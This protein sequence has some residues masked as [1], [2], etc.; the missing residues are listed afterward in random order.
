MSQADLVALALG[1]LPALPCQVTGL[2]GDGGKSDLRVLG[3]SPTGHLQAE[4]PVIDA[5]EG[6]E[7]MIKVERGRGGFLITCRVETAYFM[8]GLDGLVDLEVISVTRRKPHRA[9]Q[10][11]IVDET[12]QIDVLLAGRVAPGATVVAR[13]LDI[14][15]GGAAFLT[16]LPFDAGDQVRLRTVIRGR[17]VSTSARVVNVSRQVFGRYRV[18]CEFSQLIPSLGAPFHVANVA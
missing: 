13:L 11:M 16:D 17:P 8:G 2:H 12:A 18:G 15:A 4:L 1:V 9:T 14:S 10:R 3:A 7:I 6:G 5:R